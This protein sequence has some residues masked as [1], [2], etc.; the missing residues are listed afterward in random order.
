MAEK[1]YVTS[2]NVE[3][4]IEKIS[5]LYPESSEKEIRTFFGEYN[6][7]IWT[8]VPEWFGDVNSFDNLCE[9][10]EMWFYGEDLPF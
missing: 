2:E 1:I 8:F 9:S 3:V 5:K 10:F 4:I 7:K 6:G